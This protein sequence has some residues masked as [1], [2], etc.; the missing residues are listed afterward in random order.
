MPDRMHTLETGLPSFSGYEETE[1]KVDAL[2]NYLF[3]LLEELRYLL[4]HLDAENFSESGLEALAESVAEAAL[5][6]WFRAS[7]RMREDASWLMRP[8]LPAKASGS[9]NTR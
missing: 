8:Y 2:Q 5:A 9:E 1:E 3:M 4:R 6:G 7:W